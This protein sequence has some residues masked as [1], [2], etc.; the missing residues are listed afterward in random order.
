M[1]EQG[2]PFFA[3]IGVMAPHLPAQPAPWHQDRWPNASLPGSPTLTAPRTASFNMLAADH[4]H[5]L[6]NAAELDENVIAYVDQHMR[7]RWRSLL[8]VDDLVD[9]VPSTDPFASF[10][11]ASSRVSNTRT[12]EEVGSSLLLLPPGAVC[13]GG[14]GFM[15]MGM[16]GYGK[17]D[18]CVSATKITIERVWEFGVLIFQFQG[19]G[20]IKPRH[21]IFL[22]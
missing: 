18:L 19:F 12:A 4:F 10:S 21:N 20:S 11:S 1:A 8:A 22:F 14:G 3:Y 13:V 15:G 7:N 2:Q 9:A 6:S 16:L 5:L 17:L